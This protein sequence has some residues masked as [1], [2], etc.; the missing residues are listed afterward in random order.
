MKKNIFSALFLT[1]ILF[2][3]FNASAQTREKLGHDTRHS[4]IVYMD[5]KNVDTS[6]LP[7]NTLEELH[8]TG[9]PQDI[10]IS[11]WT[12]KVGGKKVTRQLSLSYEQLKRM[13]QTRENVLLI[14]PGF[15]ADHAEWEGVSLAA[16]LDSA[17]LRSDYEKVIVKSID[18]YKK[19]FSKEQIRSHVIFLALKVNGEV[20]PKEHG[21]PVRLVAKDLYGDKWVKWIT[22]IEVE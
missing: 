6:D 22:E 8:T 9:T 15:F 19:S 14:C 13:E 16:V 10:D 7:L 20:L 3:A 21:Y 18:G 2:V 17:A 12:L 11:T 1:A 4:K 5:P